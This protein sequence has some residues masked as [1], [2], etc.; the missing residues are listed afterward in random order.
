MYFY[1]GFFGFG[2]LISPSFGPNSRLW[3]GSEFSWDLTENSDI[4]WLAF[5]WACVEEDKGKSVSPNTCVWTSF[6]LISHV[7]V[8]V[9][10]RERERVS[11]REREMKLLKGC[12]NK[13]RLWDIHILG[14]IGSG[15]RLYLT[16][17]LKPYQVKYVTK[18]LNPIKQ[19]N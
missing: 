12:K 11:E 5:W 15:S 3:F 14:A 4:P 9:C 6:Q 17:N 13:P 1:A 10:E 18:T 7:C 2:F 16:L 19:N 8:Y